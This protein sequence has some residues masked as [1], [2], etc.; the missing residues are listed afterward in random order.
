M[1]TWYGLLI[2]NEL[3]AVIP[4]SHR[5]HPTLLDFGCPISSSLDHEIVSV[6]VEI[7]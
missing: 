1:T 2:G 6:R 3:V 5:G 7:Q 4:W